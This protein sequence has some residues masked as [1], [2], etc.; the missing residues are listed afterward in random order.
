MV[1]EVAKHR[2]N[3][4]VV[5]TFQHPDRASLFVSKLAMAKSRRDF[6]IA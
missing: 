5:L 1:H 3:A 6:A 4:F 2:I